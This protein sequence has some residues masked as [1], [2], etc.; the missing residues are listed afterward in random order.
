[1]CVLHSLLIP[2]TAVTPRSVA[3]ELSTSATLNSRATGVTENVVLSVGNVKGSSQVREITNSDRPR[4]R[5]RAVLMR[6]SA[7]CGAGLGT[8]IGIPL[9][10]YD[11]VRCHG[12]P[13]QSAR[14]PLDCIPSDAVKYAG[15]AILKMRKCLVRAKRRPATK[16]YVK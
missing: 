5:E 1:M 13:P 2:L 16:A 7:R 12:T 4:R 8:L 6:R 14:S 9:E 15:M 3:M 10:M 11:Y